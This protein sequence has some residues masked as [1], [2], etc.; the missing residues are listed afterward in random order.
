MENKTQT[1]DQTLDKTDFGHFIHTHK[2]LVLAFF[3]AIIVGTA[4]FSFYRNNV[5]ENKEQ[6]MTEIYKFSTTKLV[7]FQNKKITKEE[8]VALVKKF[9]GEF[10]KKYFHEI[11][12]H[13]DIKPDHFLELCDK[14]RSPHLWEKDGGDWKLRHPIWEEN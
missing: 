12:E 9:D 11:M 3:I 10:P 7:E 4:G 1:L 8:G 5:E 6:A 13:I 2:G 14:F